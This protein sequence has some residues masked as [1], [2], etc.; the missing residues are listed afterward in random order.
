MHMMRLSVEHTKEFILLF[1]FVS[2]VHIVRLTFRTVTGC[3]CEFHISS[4]NEHDDDEEEKKIKQTF[5]NVN[6][7]VN[8]NTNKITFLST[9]LGWRQSCC[10]Y[11][12][13]WCG[14]PNNSLIPFG[15]CYLICVPISCLTSMEIKRLSLSL[16]P[17]HNRRKGKKME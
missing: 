10:C 9:C 7:A 1:F 14:L 4:Q 16:V 13:C 8:S 6:R 11:C 2:S 15:V 3:L 5:D 12:C 17:T